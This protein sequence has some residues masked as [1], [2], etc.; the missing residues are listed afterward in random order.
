M[1]IPANLSDNVAWNISGF[2]FATAACGIKTDNRTDLLL[3]AMDPDTRVAGVFTQNQVVAAPVTLCRERLSQGTGRALIVNSGNANVANGPQGMVA[4]QN[5]TQAVAGHLHIP[6][7]TVFIAATGVIG[8]HFPVERPMA[9]LPGLVQA[10]AAGETGWEKAARAIMTTDAY[11]KLAAER[12]FIEDKPVHVLGI[13][14]GAGM[15]H[16][17]MATMLCFL[18]TDAIIPADVLQ[19]HLALAVDE[20]F[21]RSIVDGD[22][23]TND[24]VLAFAS[25]QGG[26]VCGP[27]NPD[28]MSRFTRALETVCGQLARKIVADGEG[29]SKFVTIE[30]TG[31]MTR[32]D[33]RTIAAT[34]AKSPLVKTAFAG[35]DPNWGRILAAVGYA[36][37]PLRVER[38]DMFLDTVQIVSGGVRAPGYLEKDGAAVMARKEIT[39]RID[40][41][42]GDHADAV[43]TCDLT[44]DYITI[45]A[46]YRS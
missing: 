46:D 38:I 23:S 29:A 33:A 28:A 6:E 7:E 11:P 32:K 9:A 30:V 3:V 39:V 14:K 43:W 42:L 20:T 41:G 10:L 21:N 34:V 26:V 18:F 13:A 2:R 17:N 5:L 35:S 31:A 19:T 44:H 27:A 24:T 1:T 16:P 45:N 22:T 25:G 4:A 15:I 37:V 8:E 40:L 12:F 36:G